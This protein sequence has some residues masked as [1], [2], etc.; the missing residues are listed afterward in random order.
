MQGTTTTIAHDRTGKVLTTTVRV[1]TPEEDEKYSHAH[2]DHDVLHE[3]YKKD[4]KK[5]L[6]HGVSVA[7]SNNWYIFVKGFVAYSS[8]FSL[9]RVPL[10]NKLLIMEICATRLDLRVKFRLSLGAAQKP[11]LGSGYKQRNEGVGLTE[12]GSKTTKTILL[13]GLC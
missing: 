5:S 10:S 1:H 6:G 12:T 8:C 4:L 7:L 9:C 13:L 11:R 3:K 2:H